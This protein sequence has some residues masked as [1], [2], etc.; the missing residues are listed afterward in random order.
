MPLNKDSNFYIIGFAAAVCVVCSIFVSGAAVSLKEKQKI[1]AQLDLQKNVVSVSGLSEDTSSITP[2]QL[3]TFFTNTE[4]QRIE[5]KYLDLM[6]GSTIS[7]L[8]TL[9]DIESHQLSLKGKCENDKLENNLAKLKCY[10]TQQKI[11]EVY[12]G[13]TLTRIIL[14][15]EG[16]GLWST[17]KGFLAVEK[18]GNTI[19]GLTFYSH[20]ETPGLGG[21]ID[22]P[23][24]KES[25]KGKKAYKGD[26]PAAMARK[27]GAK[28]TDYEVDGLS[29][30]TLT[31]NGVNDMMNFWL[32]E[33][34]YGNYLS[35]LKGGS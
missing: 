1:N 7:S 22:N 20:G 10:Q 19:A 30:A 16:K 31:C 12:E 17:L 11:Y 27:G 28:Y 5:T 14:P 34:G 2:E 13:S 15:V 26:K 33:K 23:T 21:E 3:K 29:G 32:G 25:W 35:K 4:G 18:D 24:W 9:E 6:K 8:K